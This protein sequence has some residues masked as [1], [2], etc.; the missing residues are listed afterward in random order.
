MMLHDEVSLLCFICELVNTC[1][2]FKR[3]IFLYGST[4]VFVL[5]NLLNL[6]ILYGHWCGGLIAPFVLE[7]YLF[8]FSRVDNKGVMGVIIAFSEG[9]GLTF[10]KYEDRGYRTLKYE[11]VKNIK[12]IK[13]E[14]EEIC[15]MCFTS[16]CFEAFLEKL[17]TVIVLEGFQTH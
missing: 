12:I 4:K 10:F 5:V 14:D 7:Y 2:C 8:G 3:E 11:E 13:V 16:T 9:R 6:L 1:I 17:S 15:K